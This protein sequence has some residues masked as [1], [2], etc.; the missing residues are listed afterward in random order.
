MVT[1]NSPRDLDSLDKSYADYPFND[2]DANVILRSNDNVDFRVHG[3]LLSMSSR[4]FRDILRLD[5]PNHIQSFQHETRDGADVITVDDDNITLRKLLAYCYPHSMVNEPIFDQAEG[6]YEVR[7]AA[8]KYGMDG[9]EKKLRM[10]LRE[11]RFMEKMPLKSFALAV[12][13]HLPEEAALA[14]KETLGLPLVEREYVEEL[15][16]IT[17]GTLHRLQA[18]HLQ[19]SK[20][21]HSIASD[22]SWVDRD[23]YTWFTCVECVGLRSSSSYVTISGNRRML[24]VS[25]WMADYLAKADVA[26]TERPIGRTVSCPELMRATLE[27]ASQCRGC[28]PKACSELRQFSRKFAAAVDL[29]ISKVKHPSFLKILQRY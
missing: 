23:D 10:V 2:M 24:V 1:I 6:L 7:R 21:A 14:A 25:K 26:V 27:K 17:G 3:L 19:C 18:Y 5:Q 28:G 22:L 29:A 8:E 16:L 12:H 15:E 13:H 9:V 11:P 20:I 4:Y